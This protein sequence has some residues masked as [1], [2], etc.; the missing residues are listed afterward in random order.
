MRLFNYNKSISVIFVAACLKYVYGFLA[1]M[2]SLQ[3]GEP[4]VFEADNFNCRNVFSHKEVVAN[5]IKILMFFSLS[6]E[7]SFFYGDPK[8]IS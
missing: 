7:Y 8:M 5:E 4:F 1:P 3:H 6:T 2:T